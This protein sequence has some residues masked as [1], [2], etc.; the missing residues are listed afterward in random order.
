MSGSPASTASA[1]IPSSAA[2]GT[3]SSASCGGG[4]TSSTLAA[5][6]PGG[7]RL[8][9]TPRAHRRSRRRRPGGAAS[10]HAA[11]CERARRRRAMIAPGERLAMVRLALARVRGRPTPSAEGEVLLPRLTLLQR[12][13]PPPTLLPF[14][15]TLL[16]FGGRA[17][18]TQRRQIA[19][20]PEL[21][22]DSS[23]QAPCAG[24]PRVSWPAAH[25][26]AAEGVSS[27]APPPH[28][29]YATHRP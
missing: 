19:L 29:R 9:P 8:P 28:L 23:W 6:R 22:D 24:R 12:A 1:L 14:A 7:N 10:T 25:L 11:G 18:R 16:A 13:P 5:P 21:T 2:Q 4:K 3:R 27:A 26:G 15:R 17:S 20:T